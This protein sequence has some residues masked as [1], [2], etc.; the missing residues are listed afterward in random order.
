MTIATRL[1]LGFGAILLLLAVVTLIGVNKVSWVDATLTNVN[2]I[3]SLKQRNAINFRGSVHDR[4]ISIRDAVLVNSPAERT[5][6]FQD[7]ETLKAF[8][9]DAAR[10]MSAIF[11]QPELAS[12]QER[13]LLADIEA[14][15]VKTL[16]LTDKVTRLLQNNQ[17]EEARQLLLQEAAPAYSEWLKRINAFIDHQESKIQQQINGVREETDGCQSLMLM[18]TALAL[19]IGVAVSYLLVSRLSRVIGGEPEH[20]VKLIRKVAA[21]DLTLQFKPRHSDSILGAVATMSE[22]LR[23]ILQDVRTMSDTLA[24]AAIQLKSAAEKNQQL[25]GTQLDETARGA[26]AIRQMSSSVQEVAEHTVNASRL[27]QSADTET[28][29]GAKDVE[30]TTETIAALAQE[31]EKAGAVIDQL[32]QRS[33]EIG[34]VVEVIE[35]IAEQ[36]NLLALNAAIEAAR[37]GEHGR[38]FA[39]VADEV[40]GLARRTQESTRDIQS[41]IESMQASALNAVGAMEKGRQQASISVDQARQAGK[42]LESIQQVVTTINDMNA[43]IA[44]AAEEQSIVAE[45]IS[46]NF[47][48]ITQASE[49]TVSGVQEIALASDELT[50]LAAR[51][52]GSVQRFRL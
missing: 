50:Q 20:A 5:P 12:D 18:A 19:V 4:A 6:H 44:S 7:I 38:G 35:T 21:G 49:L 2:D 45:E 52:Q 25:S 26:A 24:S 14:I 23:G 34:S 27:A 28:R 17:Q 41:L 3:D 16:A 11:A 10:K 15:E 29:S 46:R 40:R 47:T 48:S 13:K 1:Y 43:Q 51:L 30:V 22:G 37:A 32:S 31:V 9:Q 42:S 33:T 36:T 39:V 8:Y